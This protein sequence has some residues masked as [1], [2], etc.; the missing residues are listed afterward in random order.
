M[1]STGCA[2]IGTI[3]TSG[4][5]AWWR[6]A[7]RA[8]PYFKSADKAFEMEQRAFFY[9]KNRGLDV[10]KQVLNLTVEPGHVQRLDELALQYGCNRSEVARL[11]F[12]NIQVVQRPVLGAV[13]GAGDQRIMV[14]NSGTGQLA[15]GS[16]G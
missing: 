6:R 13:I 4:H 11:I 12:D 10:K 15:A 8:V 2:R 3:G 14:I 7:V 9:P 5:C 16:S 1:A